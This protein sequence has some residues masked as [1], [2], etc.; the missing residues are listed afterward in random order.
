MLLPCTKKYWSLF[1]RNLSSA[2]A[3]FFVLQNNC[4]GIMTNLMIW[5]ERNI[6][7]NPHKCAAWSYTHSSVFLIFIKAGYTLCTTFELSQGKQSSSPKGIKSCRTG[8]PRG[9][10]GHCFAWFPLLCFAWLLIGVRGSRA[11]APKGTK[12]CRTQGNF[13][14]SIYPSACPPQ[15]FTGL[16]FALSSLEF[17]RAGLG[18]ERMDFRFERADFRP[19]K[20]DSRPARA[21][22]R[23]ESANFK[24]VKA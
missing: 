18:P 1:T 20:A 2:T 19:V 23:P 22:F 16:K 13:W 10:Y 9:I 8:R 5:N 21:D 14:S 12:S 11:V 17:E 3:T 24:L 7:R 4:L 6:K 15:A